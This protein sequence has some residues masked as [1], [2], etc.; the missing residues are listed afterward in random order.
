MSG[1]YA[2]YRQK[3]NSHQLSAYNSSQQ[4]MNSTLLS[5]TCTYDVLGKGLQ[6]GSGM[7]ELT[8]LTMGPVSPCRDYSALKQDLQ[9]LSLGSPQEMK[10][11]QEEQMQAKYSE[12]DLDGGRIAALELVCST[13][14]F[15]LPGQCSC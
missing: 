9:L 13:H 4:C 14:L 7:Y 2:C 11:S 10:E 3:S 6:T 1:I 5:I 12:G 8:R 15:Q